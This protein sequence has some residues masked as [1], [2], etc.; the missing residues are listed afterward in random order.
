MTSY[1]GGCGDADCELCKA[2]A[3]AARRKHESTGRKF[4]TGE[5]VAQV[6]DDKEVGVVVACGRIVQVRPPKG[7]SRYYMPEHLYSL[8]R[9][10]EQRRNGVK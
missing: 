5:R 10:A 8:E 9:A 3:E 2:D 4:R 1:D 7:R 6:V